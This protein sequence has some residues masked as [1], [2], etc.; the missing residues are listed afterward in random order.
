MPLNTISAK[1]T[2]VKP[3]VLNPLP[4]FPGASFVVSKKALAGAK[5]IVNLVKLIPAGP[6]SKLMS[7]K[8]SVLKGVEP[9]KSTVTSGAPFVNLLARIWSIWACVS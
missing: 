1:E 5:S 9:L 3:L 6:V 4:E 8:S 2:P 7:K